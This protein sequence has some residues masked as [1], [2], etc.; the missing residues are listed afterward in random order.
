MKRK[1]SRTSLW[2]SSMAMEIVSKKEGFF[3]FVKSFMFYKIT[4]KVLLK[5][6]CHFCKIVNIGKICHF[7]KCLVVSYHNKT[8]KSETK[9]LGN[10]F[11]SYWP[12]CW[13]SLSFWLAPCYMEWGSRKSMIILPNH[14]QEL[15]SFQ[16]KHDT[17]MEENEASCLHTVQGHCYFPE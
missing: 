16:W 7:S 1:A 6:E 4:L 2:F 9:P 14:C 12:C 15:V 11:F 8:L 10:F 17:S 5:A 3:K 13:F